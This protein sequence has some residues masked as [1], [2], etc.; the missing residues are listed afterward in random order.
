M[1]QSILIKPTFYPLG[2]YLLFLWAK[3]GMDRSIEMIRSGEGLYWLKSSILDN[4]D[5]LFII[6]FLFMLEKLGSQI[7]DTKIVMYGLTYFL[8]VGEIRTQVALQEYRK[9]VKE[10]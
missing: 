5:V 6:G 4:K 9:T 2:I 7:L 10:I 1:I 3:R 8:L